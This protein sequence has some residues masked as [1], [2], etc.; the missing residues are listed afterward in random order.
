M[1]DGKPIHPMMPH[2]R[3]GQPAP[4]VGMD[5]DMATGRVLGVSWNHG[6]QPQGLEA[7]LAASIAG[8]RDE[9]ALLRAKVRHLSEPLPDDPGG[10]MW[11]TLGYFASRE[12]DDLETEV[13]HWASKNITHLRARVAELEA[14]LPLA[15]RWMGR[16]PGVVG[17][18][19][20]QTDEFMEAVRTVSKL[21]PSGPFAVEPLEPRDG[22]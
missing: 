15:L 5:V 13:A 3:V 20:E 14:A 6:A 2:M 19:P 16:M 22:R 11:S 21:M 8:Y 17:S 9:I 1:A 12:G 4:H 7:E 18:P 10:R